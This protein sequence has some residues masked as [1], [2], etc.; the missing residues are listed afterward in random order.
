[1]SR[2]CCCPALS[3]LAVTLHGIVL[4][5]LGL[6][7]RGGQHVHQTPKLALS[8][9]RPALVDGVWNEATGACCPA[10]ACRRRRPSCLLRWSTS[11]AALTTLQ[12]CQQRTHGSKVRWLCLAVSFTH[13]NALSSR[14]ICHQPA[15]VRCAAAGLSSKHEV[16]S[17][18]CG[19][20]TPSDCRG[21]C[22]AAVSTQSWLRSHRSGCL[23][24]RAWM[25]QQHASQGSRSACGRSWSRQRGRCVHCYVFVLL[26]VCLR[27]DLVFRTA[28]WVRA[29]LEHGH[30]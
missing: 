27:W 20:R 8:V 11:G 3:G 9:R 5:L 29:V 10:V 24:W 14:S 30:R 2:S 1:M 7:S 6:G 12:R 21:H 26:V 25:R 22:V 17:S 23:P 18:Q 13:S 19:E 15:Q 4:G 16:M 28:C